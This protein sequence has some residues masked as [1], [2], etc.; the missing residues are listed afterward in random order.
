MIIDLDGVTFNNDIAYIS[1]ENG[2]TL[3][4]NKLEEA[5]EFEGVTSNVR[6]INVAVL[7]INDV[8]HSCDLAIGLSN[9]L[10][11]IFSEHSELE[12]DVLTVDNLSLCKIE[13]FDE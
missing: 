4:L 7:D 5:I 10:I 2:S 8:Y 11:R 1:C 3:I 9:D 12:G 13:V 6:N